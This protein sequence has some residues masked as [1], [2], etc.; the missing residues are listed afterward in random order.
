LRMADKIA[1]YQQLTEG[2]YWFIIN[3]VEGSI[4]RTKLTTDQLR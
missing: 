3:N 2:H 4:I 1:L